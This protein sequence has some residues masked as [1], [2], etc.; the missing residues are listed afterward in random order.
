MHDRIAG[1]AGYVKMILPY[2]E[3]LSAIETCE[4]NIRAIAA[5]SSVLAAFSIGHLVSDRASVDL[6]ELWG[7]ALSS[8][9]QRS[10][11]LRKP[12]NALLRF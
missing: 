6:C 7:K 1:R 10:K 11:R 5:K 8:S 9:L 2:Y 4:E 3:N 12:A